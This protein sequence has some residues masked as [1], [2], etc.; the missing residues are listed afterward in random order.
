MLGEI[1]LLRVILFI[2]T[3]S[4]FSFIEKIFPRRNQ[5]KNYTRLLNNLILLIS[6][7]IISRIMLPL[8]PVA[9]GLWVTK[10]NYGLLNLFQFPEIINFIIAFIFLDLTIYL[11]HRIF[12]K[13]NIFWR[14]HKIHHSDIQIDAS[15]ALRF[16]PIEIAISLLVK[17]TAIIIIGANL[18]TIIIFE[19]LL[20]S[21]QYLIIQIFL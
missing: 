7:S 8:A 18:I 14:I 13:V 4:I 2:S 16:H 15:T 5:K 10:N 20:N 21:F 19:V 11:Q 6:G 3:L 9:I 1:S 17:S 12:H